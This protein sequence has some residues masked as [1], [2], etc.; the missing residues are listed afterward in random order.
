MVEALRLLLEVDIQLCLES[1]RFRTL[2]MATEQL[3]CG[4]NSKVPLRGRHNPKKATSWGTS[5]DNRLTLLIVLA[6]HNQGR[7]QTYVAGS[8]GLA[9]NNAC[10]ILDCLLVKKPLGQ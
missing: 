8:L 3:M 2:F 4:L 6:R 5:L 10:S 1:I 7:S 9:F